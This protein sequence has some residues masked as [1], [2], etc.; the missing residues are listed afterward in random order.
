MIK[1]PEVWDDIDQGDILYQVA[2][3]DKNIQNLAEDM[4]KTSPEG[5]DFEDMDEVFDLDIKVKPKKMVVAKVE[6]VDEGYKVFCDLGDNSDWWITIPLDGFFTESYAFCGVDQLFTPEEVKAEK[7]PEGTII[8][9][10]AEAG[11]K[12]GIKILAYDLYLDYLE[13]EFEIDL[14]DE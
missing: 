7:I 11:I 2:V 6:R 12:H 1:E 4:I 5:F 13:D 9:S 8:F 10:V 3:S 14:D